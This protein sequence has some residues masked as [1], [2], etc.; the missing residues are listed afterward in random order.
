M[1][2]KVV[3]A[4]LGAIT[5]DAIG[6]YVTPIITWGFHLH[7]IELPDAVQKGIAGLINVAFVFIG[8]YLT[9]SPNPPP[10]K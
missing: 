5:G 3:G 1:H 10:S 9:S 2:P 4:G 7:G 8:G 6:D